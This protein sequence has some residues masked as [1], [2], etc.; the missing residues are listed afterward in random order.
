MTGE[1]QPAMI[2]ILECRDSL[3]WYADKIGEMVP[4]LGDTGDEFKSREDSG[5]VNFVQ[6]HD[7]VIVK[8]KV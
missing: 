3:R 1:G 8:G 5:C 7:C 6:Y 2:M 4:Y